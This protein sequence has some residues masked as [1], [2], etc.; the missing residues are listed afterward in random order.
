MRRQFP[1]AIGERA[2]E[3]GLSAVWAYHH[4]VTP[5]AVEAATR[6]GCS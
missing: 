2:A 6:P 3:L 5:N 4:V 1:K